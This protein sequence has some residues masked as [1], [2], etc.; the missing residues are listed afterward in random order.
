MINS[1]SAANPE[2]DVVL[3]R[4]AQTGPEFGVGL[5]NHG[6]MAVDALVALGRGD[7]VRSWSEWYIGRLQEHPDARNRI[8]DEG[9]RDALGQIERVGDWIAYFDRRLEERPWRDVLDVWVA[10]LAPGMMAGATH[11]ILRTAHAVRMLAAE[12]NALR[13]HELSEGLGY[14]AARFQL[15][16][17]SSGGRGAMTASDAL[18]RVP[19]VDAGEPRT[20]L[21][22]DQ[23]KAVATL[24]FE[25][26]IDLVAASG[27]VGAFVSDLTRTFAQQYLANAA[28]AA[29]AFIHCVTAPSALR[30]LT[31]HLSETTTRAT[32]AY[33]W[34]AVAAIYSAYGT[35]PSMADGT[36][37]ME[38][39]I[40]APN[41]DDLIDRAV[42]T[43]DE[44]AIKF[45]DACLREYALTPDPAFL[46]AASDYA[47]R[48]RV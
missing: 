2:I 10:R 1:N 37:P 34:Q 35:S 28:T 26:V 4:F 27:E 24:E 21:I 17:G 15:L 11:G 40:A 8:D 13:L 19:L 5:S 39:G 31:P 29:I 20:F 6:P 48:A 38:H 47:N 3:E 25:P 9:W 23:V 32:M 43:R 7:E 33:T 44:H 36:L 14:W 18:P 45:T 41:V 12:M 16:P 22:F 46:L 42:A 30:I